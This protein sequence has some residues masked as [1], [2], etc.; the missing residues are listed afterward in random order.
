MRSQQFESS[1]SL[2]FVLFKNMGWL[3]GLATLLASSSAFAWNA[4]Q[5]GTNSPLQYSRDTTLAQDVVVDTK[6]EQSPSSTNADPSDKPRFS[7]QMVD[8]QYTVMYSPESQPSSPYP[9]ATP[10]TLGGGWSAERRC[11]EISRRLE[12]YRPDG[13]EEMQTSVENNYNIICVTTQRDPSCR[14]V[15]TVPP[16]QDPELTRNR[17]F[18]NLVVADTGQQTDAVATY[19]GTEN[20]AQWLD[21]V[22]HQ[23]LSAL[24]GP[25]RSV[26]HSSG[27]DLRPFLDPADG[28]TGTQLRGSNPNSSKT[29]LNPNRFR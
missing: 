2:R 14:I 4:N 12:L 11:N 6:P 19:V 17:V 29:R 22:V 23:G 16:G 20:A 5:V 1:P 10:T 28:G 27:I 18:E 7:C 24:G 9:W 26:K 3:A 8:G 13:L 21:R 25:N 15:L